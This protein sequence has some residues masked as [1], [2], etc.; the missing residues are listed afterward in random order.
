M[1][2]PIPA[3]PTAE[4]RVLV[5]D[6]DGTTL[7]RR[8]TVAPI[9]RA[10]VTELQ[11]RGVHVTIATG[12]IW[13]GTERIARMLGITGMV[14]CMNGSEIRHAATGR[15]VSS[16]YLATGDRVATHRVLR[17]HGLTRYLFSA[18]GVGYDAAGEPWLQYLRSWSDRLD[19]LD[20]TELGAR[21]DRRPDALAVAGAGRRSATALAV[22]ELRRTLD[23]SV[24]VVTFPSM[25]AGLWFV[26]TRDALH[27]KGTSL[28]ALVA[29]LG[30]DARH[31]VALGDWLN[32][33]PMLARAGR[34]FAMGQAPA[35]V[36]SVA[37]DVCSATF[38]RGGGIA[39]VAQRV[40]GIL[41]AEL[42]DV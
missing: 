1:T 4:P 34:S 29:P 39:E 38:E 14:A 17:R 25:R 23:P 12:R 20:S 21:I 35:G 15:V 37:S 3:R 30:L 16:R 40:W 5:L 31:C 27:D 42:A 28:D 9:D 8:R 7:T 2:T 26:K 6:L 33:L 22:E 13:S 11:R 32:D 19:G 36:K 10:A 18:D 41:P 24:E